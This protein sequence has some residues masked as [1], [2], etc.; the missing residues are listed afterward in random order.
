VFFLFELLNQK[1]LMDYAQSAASSGFPWAWFGI[2]VAL[3]A[4]VGITL[5]FTVARGNTRPVV[6]GFYGGAVRG[7]TTLPCGRSVSEAEELMAFFDSRTIK[8]TEEANENLRDL[9]D[10]LSKL[11][12]LKS[13]LMAPQ[14]TIA[15]V[16]E[17]GFATHMDIQPVADLTARCFSKT[18]PVRDLDIQFDKWKEFGLDMIRRLCTATETTEEET[19]IAERLFMQAWTDVYNVSKTSCIATL[20]EGAFKGSPRDPKPSVDEGDQDLRP[21]DGYY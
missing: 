3:A 11:C 10:L 6:S 9:R 1:G 17:L 18:I 15:A 4:I 16:R 21:Y 8:G 20:G 5:Y 7:T 13:D 2:A 12:C 14:Q 19:M